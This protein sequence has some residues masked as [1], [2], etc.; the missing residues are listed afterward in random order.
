V[1]NSSAPA[2]ANPNPNAV[3]ESTTMPMLT[4]LVFGRGPDRCAS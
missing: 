1:L 3:I 4:T 2:I